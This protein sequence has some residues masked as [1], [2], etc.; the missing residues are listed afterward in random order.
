MDNHDCDKKKDYIV[1]LFN[2]AKVIGANASISELVEDESI[3]RLSQISSEFKRLD[4]EKGVIFT[5][6][7]ISI[8]L[9][10]KGDLSTC[11]IKKHAFYKEALVVIHQSMEMAR[12]VSWFQPS[13]P[14]RKAVIMSKLGVVLHD[15]GLH[16]DANICEGEASRILGALIKQVPDYTEAH[17]E[18][19]IS[20]FQGLRNNLKKMLF[21]LGRIE[22]MMKKPKHKKHVP[23]AIERE[24]YET[25]IHMVKST[26]SQILS[27]V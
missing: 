9:E 13:L 20:R 16:K 19:A 1:S 25:Q 11:V 14:K 15:L 26:V 10:K 5:G 3:E 21:D 12:Q 4:D 23:N 17:L 18:L 2:E 6:K 8:M 7:I 24:K 22:S 27:I